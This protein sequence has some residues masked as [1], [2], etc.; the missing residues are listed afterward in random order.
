VNVWLACGCAKLKIF[1]RR[2]N[3]CVAFVQG[4][5]TVGRRDSRNLTKMFARPGSLEPLGII[6]FIDYQWLRDGVAII[7][8][9]NETPEKSSRISISSS[10]AE[11]RWNE[12]TGSEIMT[13]QFYEG[14]PVAVIGAGPNFGVAIGPKAGDPG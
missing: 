3:S 8:A 11:K 13:A 14:I 4:R 1:G 7:S 9:Q 2:V 12:T 10:G 5:I 6:I